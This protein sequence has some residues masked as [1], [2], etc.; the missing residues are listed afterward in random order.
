[1][2]SQETWF[3]LIKYDNYWP[4]LLIIYMHVCK[5]VANKYSSK[6]CNIAFNA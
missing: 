3:I 2:L 6:P 1:M 5:E 4:R